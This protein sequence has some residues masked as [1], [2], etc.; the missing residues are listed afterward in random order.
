ML[1]QLQGET[2]GQGG[3]NEVPPI[4]QHEQHQFK[5]QGYNHRRKHHHTHCHQNGRHDQVDDQKW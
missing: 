1:L 5:R 3:K 4:H 2:A